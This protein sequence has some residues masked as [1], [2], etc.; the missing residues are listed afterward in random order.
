MV[1]TVM[2]F[3]GKNVDEAELGSILRESENERPK[4]M[5]RLGRIG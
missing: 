2:K 4:R 5:D 1:R 3:I